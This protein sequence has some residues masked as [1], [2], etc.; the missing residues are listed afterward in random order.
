MTAFTS[1]HNLRADKMHRLLSAVIVL[2]LTAF[3]AATASEQIP[4]PPQSA[5]VALVGATLHPVSGPAI[6]GGT[7]LFDKGKI[8]A[9]GREV[10]LPADAVR[11]DAAGKHVWPVL[12][13]SISYL[14]LVET[15]AVTPTVDSHEIGQVNPNVRA[16]RAINPDSE[17]FPVTRA[18]GVGLAATLPEGGLLAGMGAL[19]RLDGW[20]WEQMTVKAPLCLVVEWPDMS[21]LSSLA[22]KKELQK[23]Q[24]AVAEQ[25][26]TLEEAFR[27][28]RAYKVAREA[29]GKAGVPFHAT[30]LRWEAMLPVLNREVT[31][32]V[33]ANSLAQIRA[34]VEWAERVGVRMVLVGGEEAPLAADLLKSHDIPVIVA[35]LMR[36]P[37]RRDA[38][39]DETL[40]VPEALR[41]AGVRFC[42]AGGYGEYGNERNLPYHAAMAAAYGLPRE[43]ALKAV[44]LYAAQIMG[45]DSLAGSLE[46]GKMAD[47]IV[48]DGDPLEISTQVEKMYL[49]GRDIDLG[50]HHKSLYAKYREK[51]RQENVGK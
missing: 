22:D 23:R 30:D 12:I 11:I 41:R 32:W 51:Y 9:L 43:E 42:I 39:Y 28:A 29:A 17:R 5:P 19:I 10:T 16:E 50:S 37:A 13:Q 15:G 44:T 49:D 3:S 4:A 25:L 34:A 21:G 36:L 20:T 46:P 7:I 18:N 2:C 31:V 14:G 35:P 26:D 24:A 33:F 40:T 47:I 38:A 8:V 48:T 45:V 6:E 27:Q 1:N